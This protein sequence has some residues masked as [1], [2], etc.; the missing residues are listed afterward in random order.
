MRHLSILFLFNFSFKFSSWPSVAKLWYLVKG[1][2]S[3]RI[4]KTVRS[5]LFLLFL[6]FF[7]SFFLFKK[8]W[9]CKMFGS[10]FGVRFMEGRKETNDLK[11]N[12]TFGKF[13]YNPIFSGNFQFSIII[14][15]STNLL[16]FAEKSLMSKSIC[17]LVLLG[18][19]SCKC[20]PKVAC[21]T[22]FVCLVHQVTMLTSLACII[23]MTSS[24]LHHLGDIIITSLSFLFLEW[25]AM[26]NVNQEWLV[27]QACMPC[28]P[29]FPLLTSSRWHHLDDITLMT[30]SCLHHIF[31]PYFL[32]IAGLSI[33]L[34][35]Y[36]WSTRLKMLRNYPT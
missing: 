17:S 34:S 19:R 36:Y 27:Q 8:S 16:E 11:L 12:Q 20:E 26:Q 29:S 30:S 1:N 13:T 14:F 3:L 22:S 7:S 35:N 24:C 21:S 25:P 4:N 32:K 10:H 28:S 33:W 2:R 15:A 31:L 23:L 5:N 9:P 6:F 18:G